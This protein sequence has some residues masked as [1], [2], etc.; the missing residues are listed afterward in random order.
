[1]EPGGQK[2]PSSGGF[3]INFFIN[4]VVDLLWDYYCGIVM[5]FW[6]LTGP[7]TLK[8]MDVNGIMT[9]NKLTSILRNCIVAYKRHPD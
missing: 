7:G 6:A 1:M 9:S 2:R 3:G 8:I 5:G 4:L